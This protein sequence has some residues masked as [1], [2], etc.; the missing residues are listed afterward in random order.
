MK[1]L[2]PVD[3]SSYTKR[4]L[5]WLTTHEE[6]LTGEHEFTVLTVVPQIPP[7]AASMFPPE[8]LKSYYDDTAEAIFKPIRKF[9][10]KHDMATNYVAKTGHAS[11]VIAKLADKGKFD[12]VIMGSHGHS[13]LM[14]LVMGSV[15]NQVLARCKAPV[16]LV[17]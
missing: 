15:T 6:W 13:N 14:N 9:T 4:M 11:D 8:Q 17:R 10:A 12:L 3:G 1:I 7:H 16:L 5:A 2:L